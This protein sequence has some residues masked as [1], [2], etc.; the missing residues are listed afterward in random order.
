MSPELIQRTQRFLFASKEEMEKEHIGEGL[1]RHILRLRDIYNYWLANP[2]LLDRHIVAEI[3]SRYKVSIA[4]AYQDLRLIKICLGNLNQCT[5]DYYRWVFLA[6]AE[7]AFEMARKKD[8]PKAFASVLSAFGK[9]ARLDAPDAAAPDYSAIVPQQFTITSDPTVAGFKRI[10]NVE[11]KIRTLLARYVH[12]AE[13]PQYAV[14]E[15]VKPLK[16][17]LHRAQ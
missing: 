13:S 4:Q 3:K 8:D 2:Q 6:R 5:T 7:E 12:E 11:G 15:E 16:P 9:Y 1:Q 14:A 10:P 17:E